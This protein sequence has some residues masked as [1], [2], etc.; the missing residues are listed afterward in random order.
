MYPIICLKRAALGLNLSSTTKDEYIVLTLPLFSR[1][2]WRNT[3]WDEKS[4]EA[5]QDIQRR[6]NISKAQLQMAASAAEF[7][8][9]EEEQD[10][11][12]EGSESDGS[13]D[14]ENG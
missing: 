12:E 11:Y 14:G 8:G 7:S 4:D 10:Q 3:D 5:D 9:D 1:F 6:I 2:G 13:S